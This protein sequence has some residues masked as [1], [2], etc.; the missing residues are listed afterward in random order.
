MDMLH[1][2]QYRATRL[3]SVTIFLALWWVVTDG[4][5]LFT[6]FLLPSPTSVAKS[7][8]SL[9]QDGTI[10]GPALMAHV[11]DSARRV[12]M[13]FVLGSLAALTVGTVAGL[14]AKLSRAIQ[15][16]VGFLRAI[17][18]I[19]FVPLGIVWFGLGE[20]AIVFIIVLAAFWTVLP[21]VVGGVSSTPNMYLRASQTLGA[22]P[23]QAFFRVRL[24]AAL[25]QI[26][27]GL[28][29]GLGLSWSAIVAAELI[30]ASTGLGSLIMQA[31]GVLRSADM[32]AGMVTIGLIGVA[33]NTV[34]VALEARMSRHV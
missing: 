31:R 24:R 1:S 17:P 28:R 18:P 29:V 11:A 5:K 30:A 12:A 25:P 33:L 34:L 7:L 20:V 16:L 21:S 10:Y 22:S 27:V 2:N 8:L 32:V 15:P 4:V 14:S 19:T 26:V 9:L 13:G 6:P 3:A 23:T